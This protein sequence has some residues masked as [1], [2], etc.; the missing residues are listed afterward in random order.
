M[1][2]KLEELSG[3]ELVNVM[4]EV[5][6]EVK[7]RL[8][9]GTVTKYVAREIPSIVDGVDV[10]EHDGK[11]LRRVSRKSKTGDF[12]RFSGLELTF[13]KNDK[14]YEVFNKED[15]I[16]EGTM[17]FHIY[18]WSDCPNPEIFEVVGAV[19]Q[20]II[21]SHNQQRAELI[22]RAR[23]FVD[24]QKNE[25]GYYHF[26]D[27]HERRYDCIAEFITNP[28]KRTVTCIL[29]GVH[30]DYVRKRAVAR[31]RPG[32]VFNERIGE[33]ISLCMALQIDIPQEFMN[34]VQP[35]E[36]VVG[37]VVENKHIGRNKITRA[38]ENKRYTDDSSGHWH[39]D[40]AINGFVT[41]LDDTNAE[42]GVAE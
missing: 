28:E 26:F 38:H 6:A 31:C 9:E 23:E 42:Y 10:V 7:S 25:Y 24:G 18:S 13:T 21:K 15:Y 14:F 39:V 1:T 3:T 41:I 30:S 29:R 11:I 33:V 2:M 20:E 37:M 12:V 35:D 16:G 5:M 22:Q 19:P 32:E 27:K 36:V 8:V 4:N 40:S 34:A 17:D